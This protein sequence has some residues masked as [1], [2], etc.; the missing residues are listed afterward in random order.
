MNTSTARSVDW[1]DRAA[2][3]DLDGEIFFPPGAPGTEGSARQVEQ[4]RSVCGTCTVT[5]ACLTF[6]IDT[7]E[8]EGIWAGT[9]P[10]ERSAWRSLT[11][12]AA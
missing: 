8:N 5:T 6:A 7:R 3:R 4:A 1:R 9:T 12:G 10:A 11:R 2:C